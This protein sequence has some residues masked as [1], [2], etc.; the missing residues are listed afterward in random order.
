M[1]IAYYSDIHIDM[2]G[3]TAFGYHFPNFKKL[4]EDE[5]DAIV[6]AG[7]IA[8][9]SYEVLMYI[10]AF[11]SGIQSA[12]RGL[13]IPVF[14]VPG[15]HEYYEVPMDISMQ[16]FWE[17]EQNHK[18]W[19]YYLSAGRQPI[20]LSDG[21]N[22]TVLFMGDTLWTD[23]CLNGEPF[24]YDHMEYA[25]GRMSDYFRIWEDFFGGTKFSPARALQ[26]HKSA[27]QELKS[28][29][30]KIRA[31]TQAKKIV[32]VSHH[33]PS[34]ESIADEYRQSPWDTLN[35]AYAS[36]LLDEYKYGYVEAFASGVNLWIHG[37]VHG[38]LDYT[39]DKCRVVTNP[40]G[41]TG[42]FGEN[43]NH[44]FTWYKYVT[45]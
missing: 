23:Y 31:E 36:A 1:K 3:N 15:N 2:R 18:G 37:H 39:K 41:Y 6:L 16:L 14:F 27:V 21:L 29:V 26:L 30:E 32:V 38:T 8:N 7:D 25:S 13:V 40:R 28:D 42:K 33:A 10:D 17:Y 35:P 44:E 45:V 34:Y 19:F 22:P 12:A 4:V 43:E 5:V 11:V 9:R 24:Q 20:E